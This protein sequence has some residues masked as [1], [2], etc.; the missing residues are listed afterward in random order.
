[1]NSCILA[2]DF[3]EPLTEKK[4]KK[5]ALLLVESRKASALYNRN[6]SAWRKSDGVCMCGAH[7]KWRIKEKK[8]RDKRLI[9]HR[10]RRQVDGTVGRLVSVRGGARWSLVCCDKADREGDLQL[11]TRTSQ[12]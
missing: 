11:Q 9:G 8:R 2:V 1:M 12:K 4:R 6:V 10:P 5:S 7:V 3:A